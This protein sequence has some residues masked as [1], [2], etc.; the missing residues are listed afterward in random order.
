MEWNHR[1]KCVLQQ[2]PAPENRIE[3][4]FVCEMLW[5]GITRV[6]F[7]FVSRNGI[8]SCFLFHG[9]I[10]TKLHV[11]AFFCFTERNSELFSL[12]RNGLVWNSENLLLFVFHKTEFQAFFSPAEW[13]GA[14]FREF[15]VPRNSRNSANIFRSLWSALASRTLQPLQEDADKKVGFLLAP[16]TGLHATSPP[17]S[18][19]ASWNLGKPLSLLEI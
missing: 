2:N 15:S 3:S 10:G 6:C 1:K 17:S 4:F 5:N 18:L 14:K 16:A 7:N 11:F 9:M 13:F 12:P 8:P 19:T